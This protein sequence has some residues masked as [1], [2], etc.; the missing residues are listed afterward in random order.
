MTLFYVNVVTPVR[1]GILLSVAFF[2]AVLDDSFFSPIDVFV[3]QVKKPVC[4][5]KICGKK[6]GAHSGKKGT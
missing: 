5:H 6:I 4:L 1:S 2:V 3:M